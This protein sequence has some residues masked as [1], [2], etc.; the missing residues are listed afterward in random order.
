MYCMIL[1][2]RNIA[3]KAYGLGCNDSPQEASR[4]RSGFEFVV[5][6]G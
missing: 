2:Y 1:S 3:V 4:L 6:V 5:T